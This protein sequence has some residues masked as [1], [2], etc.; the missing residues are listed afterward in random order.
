MQQLLPAS[1]TFPSDFI[2]ADYHS[3]VALQNFWEAEFQSVSMGTHLQT[4]MVLKQHN[5]TQQVSTFHP[6]FK[7][8]LVKA[9]P[10]LLNNTIN[11]PITSLQSYD[12]PKI[13]C[14]MILELRC[15]TAFGTHL[16]RKNYSLFIPH[17][18]VTGHPVFLFDKSGNC[19]YKLLLCRLFIHLITWVL[20]AS[21]CQY[22]ELSIGFQHSLVIKRN[23]YM[24][25]I[26]AKTY[27]LPQTFSYIHF[28]FIH[29]TQS[30]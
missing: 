28:S 14:N 21:K 18:H 29:L 15:H 27:Y 23:I 9:L 2:L 7:H 24:F 20:I 8:N 10:F 26:H 11:E 5:T 16:I 4:S 6:H 22:T 25:I 19:I 1:L 12:L 17:S 3:L 13:R 30:Y